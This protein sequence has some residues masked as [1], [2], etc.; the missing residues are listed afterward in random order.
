M[1]MARAVHTL[2]KPELLYTIDKDKKELKQFLWEWDKHYGKHSAP[3][4]FH[5][6]QIDWGY[7]NVF[8]LM[9]CNTYKITKTLTLE[10]K[11]GNKLYI[12]PEWILNCFD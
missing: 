9:S 3:G 12:G 5:K 7:T 4:S 6:V 1:E 10:T 8:G 11:K 2:G